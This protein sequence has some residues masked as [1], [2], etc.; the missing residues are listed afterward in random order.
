MVK[1]QKYISE[2]LIAACYRLNRNKNNFKIPARNSSSKSR[3]RY[4]AIN[5]RRVIQ[6]FFSIR[7]KAFK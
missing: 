6:L 1:S 7:I 3:F 2:I 4:D 5:Y